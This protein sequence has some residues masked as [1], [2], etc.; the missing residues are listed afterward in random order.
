M[1]EELRRILVVC[2]ERILS[3]L[4]G[5]GRWQK[6]NQNEY[7]QLRGNPKLGLS[8]GDTVYLFD[9]DVLVP[10]ALDVVFVNEDGIAWVVRAHGSSPWLHGVNDDW[11]Y[12][13]PEEAVLDRLDEIREANEWHKKN[14]EVTDSLLNVLNGANDAI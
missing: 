14:A 7:Y 10:E 5:A 9:E 2:C 11:F 4:C 3:I 8:V 12:D 6:S 13:S 1:S